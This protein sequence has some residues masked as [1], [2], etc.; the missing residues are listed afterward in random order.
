MFL[1]GGGKTSIYRRRPDLHD[2]GFTHILSSNEDS[3]Q[4]FTHTPESPLCSIQIGRLRRETNVLNIGK[5]SRVTA[6]VALL[7]FF[8]SL[9]LFEF[10]RLL[11]SKTGAG[12]P[13]DRAG[14]GASS[15]A[16][17]THPHPGF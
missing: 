11:Q 14:R 8:R 2:I 13:A 7:T 3:K 1:P 17:H 4:G 16:T 15:G 12:G 10:S 5:H 9:R 6:L